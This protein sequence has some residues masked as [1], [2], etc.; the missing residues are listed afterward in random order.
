M[1]NIKIT[2]PIE[3]DMLDLSEL[4]FIMIDLKDIIEKEINSNGYDAKIDE[5]D[6]LIEYI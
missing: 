1:N 2:M 4:L 5:E 6:I 3:T